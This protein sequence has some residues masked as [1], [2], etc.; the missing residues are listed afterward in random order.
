M[1]S[2]DRAALRSGSWESDAQLPRLIPRYCFLFSSFLL[3]FS[4]LVFLFFSFYLSPSPLCL[5]FR[6]SS[7]PSLS[8]INDAVL[9]WCSTAP[10]AWGAPLRASATARVKTC[11]PQLALYTRSIDHR[12]VAQS[13]GAGASKSVLRRHLRVS[14]RI[15]IRRAVPASSIGCP[16]ERG[17]CHPVFVDRRINKGLE[18]THER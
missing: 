14:R 7:Y 6:A 18:F 5:F 2:F 11:L 10:E 3:V 9:G 15:R 4:F 8:Q 16:M 13:L 12:L 17:Q 1:H